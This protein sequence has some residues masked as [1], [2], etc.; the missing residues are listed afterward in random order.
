MD[1]KLVPWDEARIHVLTHTFHYGL[2]AFEGIRAYETH[3]GQSAVFRLKDHVRRLADSCH[4]GQMALPFTLDQVAAACKETLVDNGLKAGYI[5]PVV[6]IGDGVMGV[7]P[8]DNPIRVV[9]AV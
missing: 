3:D 6:Y 4:I 8:A 1:G 7:H 9:I 2:G 5:R